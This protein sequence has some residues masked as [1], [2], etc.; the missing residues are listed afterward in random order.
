MYWELKYEG[1]RSRF[2]HSENR[3][4]ERS[5]ESDVPTMPCMEVTPTMVNA[6]R[7]VLADKSLSQ[8]DRNLLVRT[9]LYV[10]PALRC[11]SAFG[12]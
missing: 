11:V 9:P 4:E 10:L 1:K 5:E 7:D 2:A 8:E 6:M 3:K 12:A